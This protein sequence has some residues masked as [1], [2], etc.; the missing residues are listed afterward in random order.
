[1]GWNIAKHLSRSH[2]LWIITRTN[3]REVIE[4]CDE[5]WSHEVHWVFVDP[6]RWMTFWKRGMRGL[7]V[8]YSLWQIFAYR[9][10]RRLA[11]E[12]DLDL[13]HHLTFG[14]Y[15]IP[16]P[17]AALDAPFIFGPVGGGE[18][19]PPELLRGC[20][21][22]TRIAESGR[23]V[24]RNLIPRLPWVRGWY[25]DAAWTFAATGQTRDAL[26]DIGVTRISVLRQSGVGGDE[27]ERFSKMK[28]DGKKPTDKISLV[29]ASRLVNWKAIDLAIEAV[30]VAR[31]TGHDVELTVLQEGP[32]LLRLKGV[33]GQ[34]GMGAHVDF[35]G[36]LP[37]LED[38]YQTIADADALIH[39]ALHE[40]F[41]QVCLESLAL[42]VPVITMDWAGPGMIVNEETGYLVTPGDREQTVQRLADA[43]AQ[44]A[45][46]KRNGVDKSEA[47]R[48]RASDE[49]R[50][51]EL[52]EKIE[53][54]YRRAV[55]N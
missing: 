16:S 23:E 13:V 10:A 47:C 19:T 46:D 34:L 32:E 3:N 49:F 12:V 17:L 2:E 14:K 24:L 42:G 9:A 20:H 36:R 6:P 11:G 37:S 48:R 45:A 28:P 7:R 25:R 18:S 31:K 21:W 5:Q 44:L 35:K 53:L 43:I 22:K 38:V 40:A 15:W 27:V 8:F 50:W 55:G 52:V 54:E 33:R 41:G 26:L 30:C 1:M 29:A 4:R 51:P 39:P